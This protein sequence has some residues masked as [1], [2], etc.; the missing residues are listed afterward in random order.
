MKVTVIK[1]G[2]TELGYPYRN[3]EQALDMFMREYPNAPKE[4]I[5]TYEFTTDERPD[6]YR[7]FSN[8]GCIRTF[9]VYW[10]EN[11]KFKI[12]HK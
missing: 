7:A 4:A 9:K 2:A 3:Y 8:A 10:D 11:M 6:M 1:R 5:S 12:L